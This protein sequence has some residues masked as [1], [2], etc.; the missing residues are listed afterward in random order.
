MIILGDFN[1]GVTYISP[2]EL[3]PLRAAAL[4]FLWIVPDSA[5]TTFED[6][7]YTQAHDRIVVRGDP[8]IRRY[9]SRWGVDRIMSSKKVSDHFPVWAEFSFA[10][11]N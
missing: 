7:K 10:G 5:D 4:P 6:G 3:A 11:K 9:T 2:A 1:A 8:L